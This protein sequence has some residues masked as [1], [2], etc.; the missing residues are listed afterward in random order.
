MHFAPTISPAP[1]NTDRGEIES[2]AVALEYYRDN[3]VSRVIMQPKYMGSY[4][5]IYLTQDIKR[6]RFFSRK[7]FLI[8]KRVDHAELIEAVRPLHERF[9]WEGVDMRLIQSELMPWSALGKGLIERDFGGYERSHRTHLDYIANTGLDLDV[10]GLMGDEQYHQFLIDQDTL[11]RK[12][13]KAKYP[14]HIVKQ[15]EALAELQLP[16][17]RLYLDAINLYSDQLKIYGA[18]D[19]LHFKPFNILKTVYE[20]G[21]EEINSSNIDG[22]RAVSDEPIAIVD[23]SHEFAVEVGYGFFGAL[24]RDDMEG[25]VIKPDNVRAEGMAPMFK[26]RNDNYLQMIY[27]INFKDNYGYYL[28]RRGV[29]KKMRCSSNQWA[30]AQAILRIPKAEIDDDNEE[31]RRLIKARILEE[32]FEFKLDPRL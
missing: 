22:F 11:S 6:T 32:D 12:E 3:G 20:D 14:D 19:E 13:L 8:S 23:P 5:D 28:S 7:G 29:G 10:R 9:D 21:T 15:Y 1:K 18:D 24:V 25:I 2:I 17:V 26:V 27:G 4:C 31:Y 16:D 30:I